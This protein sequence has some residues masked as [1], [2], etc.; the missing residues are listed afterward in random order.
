MA[1]NADDISL[2]YQLSGD[3]SGTPILFIHGFPLTGQMWEPAIAELPEECFCIVP[4]LRGLGESQARDGTSMTTYADDLA[5]LLDAVG[6]KRPVIVVALS[7]GGYIAFELF[8]RHRDKV[9]ALVLVDTRANPDSADARAGR[10]K[11]IDNVKANGSKAV[12]DAMIEKLF[13]PEV[14]PELKQE[15]HEIMAQQPPEGVIGALQAMADRP[16]SAPTLAKIDC[17]TLLLVGEHDVIT[18]PDVHR[19]MQAAIRGS[20]LEVIADCGHM[21]PVEKPDEFNKILGEFIDS[22]P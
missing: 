5:E 10:M 2:Y 9:K 13:A 11:M 4:D 22:L 8:R 19:E 15:W 21:T 14:D 12:A 17:P 1:D 18:P 16:D 7:M 3:A 6:E 20:R